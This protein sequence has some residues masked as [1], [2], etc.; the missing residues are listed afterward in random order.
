M[1][2]RHFR[3]KLEPNGALAGS[4]LGGVFFRGEVQSFLGLFDFGV[5]VAGQDAPSFRES[6]VRDQ[7]SGSRIVI[8]VF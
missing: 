6:G 2:G 7:G 4:Q 1:A 5:D 3:Q 8:R